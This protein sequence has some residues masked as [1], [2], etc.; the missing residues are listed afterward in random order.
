[1][2]LRKPHWEKLCKRAL[3]PRARAVSSFVRI[4]GSRFLLNGEK[5]LMMIGQ[6]QYVVGRPAWVNLLTTISSL[7]HTHNLESPSVHYITPNCLLCA[8]NER[9]CWSPRKIRI[10]NR[11]FLPVYYFSTIDRVIFKVRRNYTILQTPSRGLPCWIACYVLLLPI[12]LA[13]THTHPH[14]HPVIAFLC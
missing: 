11:A 2:I 4:T 13:H 14:T 5:S 3:F 6:D 10:S 1:M 12:K 9:N 8:G 7:S